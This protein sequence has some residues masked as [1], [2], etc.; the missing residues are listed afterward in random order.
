VIPSEN[1][2]QIASARPSGAETK[3][4]LL[5]TGHT[6]GIGRSEKPAALEAAIDGTV[7]WFKRQLSADGE[8]K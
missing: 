4:L 3:I 7:G 1:A 5:R 2:E 8:T 6:F